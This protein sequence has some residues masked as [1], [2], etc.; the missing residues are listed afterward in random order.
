MQKII[1]WLWFDDQAEE[2]ANFYVSIFKDGRIR[3]VTRYPDAVAEVA[4]RPKG[5]V[6][7]VAFELFEQEFVAMNGGPHATFSQAIS[8]YVNCA[9][10]GEVDD[11]WEKLSNGGKTHECGWLRDKYGVSW[12]IVPEV[13]GEMLNENDPIKLD[14]MMQAVVQMK[15]LDT[16]TLRKACEHG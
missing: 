9:T 14:R 11:L 2:A 7:T 8:L 13:V 3:T 6:M 15:K 4:G 16:E 12:Q 10:Q 5:S 1:P